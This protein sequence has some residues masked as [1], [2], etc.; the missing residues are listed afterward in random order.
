[1]INIKRSFSSD[2]LMKALTGVSIKEFQELAKTFAKALEELDNRPDRKRRKGGGKHH[3]L[4]SAEEKLFFILFYLKCYATF[5][6]FAFFYSVVRS[7][8]CR[9]VGQYLPVLERALGR[10]VVLPVRKIESIEEFMRLFPNVK[11]VF[12]DGT[13][14][15]IQRPKDPEK[16]KQNYSG[17][18][19][20]HTRKNLVM[21]DRK[22]R[23]LLLGDTHEG[24]RHDKKACDQEA[25]VDPLPPD[26]VTAWL[27]CGFQGIGRDHPRVKI[28]IPKK[29]PK[30][31]KL[32]E[33]EKEYNREI[34]RVRIIV[35]NAL[36]GVKRYRVVYDV[37]RNKRKGMDDQVM[38][39]ACGLWN[40]HLKMAA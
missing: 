7:Q 30:G 5:D 39:V 23:I 1:M 31:G 14:R 37:F 22:K 6:V 9:W 18:K 40:Y 27:D 25:I 35:E 32:T 15:S 21:S 38:L 17:K 28:K 12:I 11:D 16:Q 4:G 13:E 29:K 3:T 34:S 26:D 2:R 19:K 24:K 33:E 8:P 36:A 10:E 20:R